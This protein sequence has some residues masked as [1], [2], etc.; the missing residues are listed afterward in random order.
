MKKKLFAFIIALAMCI[1][2]SIPAFADS[3]FQTEQNEPVIEELIADDEDLADSI[4]INE[5]FQIEHTDLEDGEAVTIRPVVSPGDA[6]TQSTA[7][8]LNLSVKGNSAGKVTGTVT[9]VGSDNKTKLDI[10]LQSKETGGSWANRDQE[11]NR[12]F[13][14]NKSISVSCETNNTKFFRVKITG[15]F[16]GKDAEEAT[17]RV[18]FNK[19]A[20]RYPNVKEV[21]SGKKCKVPASNLKVDKQKRDKRFRTKYIAHFEEKYPKANIKWTNYQI[22]HMRPIK[23]GGGNAMSNGIALTKDQH[24]K[25]NAWWN[26]Y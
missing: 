8:Y 3:E 21:Y 22:H 13:T 10:F 16:L 24:D 23:Y 5:N 14:K 11:E 25:F 9:M 4:E 2:I 6:E 15:K 7:V 1:S 20:V 19:K 18:L 12:T 17:N 26:N